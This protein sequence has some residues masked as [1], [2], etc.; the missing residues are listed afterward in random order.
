MVAERDLGSRVYVLESKQDEFDRRQREQ[1]DRQRVQEDLINK[2][3]N[4][5]AVMNSTL[6]ML[7]NKVLPKVEEM[8]R[9]V[10]ANTLVTKSALWLV[11]VIITAGL[12]AIVAMI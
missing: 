4:N 11:G 2:I 10:V 9:R 3:A 6:E 7:T 5:T 12:T 1:E 8:E